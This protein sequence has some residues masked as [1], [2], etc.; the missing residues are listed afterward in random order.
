[1]LRNLL[2]TIGFIFAA[3]LIV[4]SQSGTLKG[5]ILDKETREPIPFANVVL[6]VG[7]TMA[8]GATSDFDGNYIIKPIQPG[9]YDL[10]ATYVGYKTVLVTGMVINSDQITF[11]DIEMESTAAQLEEIVVTSYKVPLIDKDKTVTGGSVTAE[12][13]K[14][15]P[16]RDANAIATTIGGVFSADGE[17]GSVRGARSDQTV[18]YIDGIRV[19]G[20]SSLP[21]SAIEQVSVY[22]GGLP[23]QYGDARGGIINVTTKGPS[24]TFGAG[25]ELET[26]K[27]LDA[28]G[29]SRLG[30]NMQG[31]LIKGKKERQ[32]S[33]LGYFISGDLSYREDS[34]PTANGVYVANDDYLNYL[35][36]T[37]LRSAGLSGGGTFPNGEF[38]RMN[39]LENQKAT[40]NTSRYGINLSG[41]ID[42]RTTQ[43]TN[44]TFGG[45]FNYNDGRNFSFANSMYNYDRNILNM[46]NT[47]RVFGR[48][49]QR[50]PTS[51]ESRSLVKNV[52][53]SL[54]FDY[55]Q[56]TGRNMDPYHKDDL[57][58][59]GYLGTYTTYKRPTYEL[60]NITID[61]EELE[62]VWLQN[63]WD[64][65]T[66]YIFNAKDDNPYLAR[67]TSQIYEF[68]PEKGNLNAP[69]GNWRSETDLT[70]RGGLLNGQSPDAF[71]GLWNPPGVIQTR[72]AESNNTLISLNASAAADI[73]NHELKF[74]FLYEQR[75][76]RGFSYNAARLWTRMRGLTNNHIRDLDVDNPMPIYQDGI[77]QDTV[78]YYRKYT[79]TL[80]FRFDKSLRQKLG[81]DEQG[82]DFILVDSYDVDNNTIQYYDKDGVLHTTNVDGDLYSIDMFSAD[83]LLENG[84]Y[85][86]FYYGYDYKGNKLTSRPS[87]DDFF[88]KLDD[89]GDYA[90]PIAAFEPIY[91]AGYIQD[92]FAFKDLI[93]N[94]GVRVDRFDA[95]QPVL[96]D[97]FL[98]YEARTVSEVGDVNGQIVNHPG[99]MGS[100]YVVYVDNASN[101]TMV[102]GYRDE[103]TWYNADGVEI[104][105][106]NALDAG[107]GVSPYLVNPDQGA[108]NSSAFKDYE[109]Q[110]SVMPRISFSF[111]ISDEALFFAHYDVL[112][113]RPLNNV[114]SNPADYFFINN[115]GGT[116]LN[117]PNLKPTKTID[118]ELGFQQ[119]LTNKSSL[120]LTA[121]YREMRDDIQIYRFNGA[122][123]RD[124]TSYN[125]LDFGT[126]K[127]LTLTYDL[128]RLNSN[129]RLNASYTLQFADGTGSSAT[130]SAALIN[131]GLPNLRTLN[132]LNW[133]RRHNFNI[134]LDYR[135]SDGKDYN[136]PTITR[137]K[138]TDSE[139][140]VQLLK[141]TGVNFQL[142][143]GSGT[144]YTAQEN[145]TSIRSGGTRVLKGTINGSRL[146]WQFRLDMRLDKDIYLN[147]ESGN[148]NMYLNIYLQVLNV[149]DTKNV[150]G[151]YP[152][153]GVPDDDGYLAAAEWQREINEQLDPIS[154]RMYYALRLDNPGNYSSPRQIRIGVL[155]NF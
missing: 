94:V 6:E 41:K 45:Q 38:A 29:Q 137:K 3:N 151:V 93:F 102:M 20:S 132:P 35:Q 131:S 134:S 136:G 69:V 108:V 21:Q 75:A 56:V 19:I 123:P 142:T 11:F 36:Q 53:Y 55:S 10:K 27:F 149:L 95:N 16:N 1:M 62:N 48:F 133:D 68:F 40:P 88:T 106:P 39:D 23:A 31:P 126:V 112:T 17:R 33:L 14:K 28:F 110:W 147:Q 82:L 107:S 145:I 122:Y 61:G 66:A 13:I 72:Y 101:P 73:G 32:T 109:P 120:R 18:M 15:M 59:Y 80:Q 74:G 148:K 114:R 128:R 2:L 42:V 86:A 58:K 138:G 150:L 22:L 127:G 125:N 117:N 5:K 116:T 4:F 104:Q 144:P 70:L 49:T 153:T 98:L 103:F 143:G 135:F 79:E 99:N 52:Y 89:R 113:Q 139:K 25:L 46:G 77:F 92:K 9:T 124:Y 43:Y 24:R 47:W 8:G 81:L 54:Q 50:F 85:T 64:S 63:S 130:T 37:P 76:E 115:L 141:N 96:K 119:K 90:R 87:L 118:Y 71:Y 154:Y 65:D 51:N 129:T 146:P 34:R 140:A 152:A 111:P 7:G 44:L 91:M 97:P 78:A 121:F 100:D 12:D 57:F 105:D 67:Y 155:F 30:F 83:E 60:G 26:S 84:N